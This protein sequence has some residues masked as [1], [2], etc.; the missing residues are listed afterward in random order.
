MTIHEARQRLLFQLYDLYDSR[1]AAN[2]ADLVMEKITGWMKIDRVINKHLPLNVQQSGLLE[3]YSREL[4]QGRP[5]QY[6]L[7][8]AWFMGAKFY[9][10]ERVLIPRP[11]TEEL[12]EWLIKSNRGKSLNIL[13]IGTGSGCIPIGLKLNLPS[14]QV[15]SCDIS[16]AALEVATKNAAA[17]NTVIHFHETDILNRDAWSNLPQSEIIISNPPYVPEKDKE[18]MNR[19]VLFF[20]P[21]TALFVPDSDPLLFYRA[22][23]EFGRQKLSTNGEVYLEIHEDLSPEV[24]NALSEAGYREIETRKDLQGKERMIRAKK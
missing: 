11:E 19:N 22:I 9:V 7:G 6:V 20:E 2:I 12:L 23:A 3:Q 14:C 1:E 21:H 13:D 8:E 4:G 16:T 24:Q 17:H 5:V 15:H 18:N 10:D